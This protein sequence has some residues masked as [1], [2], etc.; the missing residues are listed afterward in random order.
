MHESYEEELLRDSMERD[1]I[2]AQMEWFER[3]LT[4]FRVWRER[5]TITFDEVFELLELSKQVK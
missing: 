1:T 3:E 5:E 2:T 4:E